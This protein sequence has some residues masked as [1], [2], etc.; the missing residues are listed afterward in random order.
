MTSF[1]FN[2]KMSRLLIL[3]EYE[4]GLEVE[5]NIYGLPKHLK[6]SC[7]IFVKKERVTDDVITRVKTEYSSYALAEVFDGENSNESVL[8]TR[9]STGK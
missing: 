2:S 1:D 3:A 9:S 8:A 5:N 6:V 4:V 7:L